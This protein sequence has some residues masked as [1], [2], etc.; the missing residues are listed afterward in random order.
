[1]VSLLVE[2][3]NA[4]AAVTPEQIDRVRC[5]LC[6]ID[7]DDELI[8]VI[9]DLEAQ[10]LWALALDYERKAKLAAHAYRYDANSEDEKTQ[11]AGQANRLHAM[12]HFVREM[13]WRRMED[14]AGS[15]L[16]DRGRTVGLCENFSLVSTPNVEREAFEIPLPKEF[17]S[18]LERMIR[19]SRR[20]PAPEETEKKPQ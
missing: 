11:L 7:D 5:S 4:V 15:P 10:R 12:E 20:E 3:F 8:M 18:L 9:D 1:M 13:A 2:I 19:G 6:P 17:G 16:L 14:V